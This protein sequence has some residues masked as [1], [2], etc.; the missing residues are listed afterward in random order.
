[1]G[2]AASVVRATRWVAI[3]FACVFAADAAV[4][5]SARAVLAIGI[6]VAVG[7]WW[8][9]RDQL[10]NAQEDIA[11]AV[12][13]VTAAIIGEPWAAF[14]PAIVV[15]A[16]GLLLRSRFEPVEEP[17]VVAS[18]RV[19]QA[20]SQP[21]PADVDAD[22]RR[23]TGRLHGR[24]AEW[25]TFIQI[26]LDRQLTRRPN[27]ELS[28]LRDDV[29]ESIREVNERTRQLQ[30]RITL[31]A[32]LAVE[33]GK[34]MEWFSDHHGGDVTL[35]IV[36]PDAHLA[37]EVEQALLTI[38]HES[39]DNVGRHADADSV[40]VQWDVSANAATLTISDDGA[41]FEPSSTTGQGIAAMRHAAASSGASLS[42]DSSPGEGTIVTAAITRR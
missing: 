27:R 37:P 6:A 1:M 14:I 3:V 7:V 41:G 40:Q 12:A 42:I 30:A 33:A 8:T 29:T 26:E 24:V 35:K 19:A 34:V 20:L 9:L 28:E 38:L 22:A 4:G 16:A 2:A 18:E 13:L 32:P 15:A 25:L 17:T 21:T 10:V 23:F 31:K 36:D 5:G 11:I 39:I